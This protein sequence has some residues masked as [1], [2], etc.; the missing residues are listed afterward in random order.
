LGK[1]RNLI[2]KHMTDIRERYGDWA[3]V[4]GSAIG[5]GKAFCEE[6]ARHGMNLVMVD[7]NEEKL[8]EVSA[9]LEGEYHIKTIPVYQDLF[10]EDTVG[11]I[12]EVTKNLEVRLLLYVAAY[13]KIKKFENFSTSDFDHFIHIN[14]STP[15]KLVQAFSQRLIEK[16]L[17][18]GIL[19]MSSLAGLLGMQYIVPYAASKAFTWNLAESLNHEFKPYGIDVMTCIA[20]ATATEAYLITNPQYGII[21]PQVQQPEEVAKKTLRKL[22]KQAIYMPGYSNRFNYFILTRILPRKWASSI[23]NKTMSKMYAKNVVN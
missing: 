6:L 12:M 11:Q 8:S 4:A 16:K 14:V 17:S 18:G 3:I 21:K 23:A 5:L 22:G 10:Q 9:T 20:G 7:N 15:L 2:A 1:F 19:L 13:S